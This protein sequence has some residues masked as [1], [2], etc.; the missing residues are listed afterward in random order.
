MKRNTLHAIALA[1]SMTPLAW[2]SAN[3]A[4]GVALTHVHG[5]T[6]A[7]DGATLMVPSHHGLAV[8]S[9]GQWSKA[10]GPEHDY[11][12]FAGTR[13]A[14]YSS[15]HPAPGSGLKN[16]F[17]L[18]KSTDGGKSWKQL[19]LQGESDFHTLAAS[20]GTNAVY[21]VN[22][23]PNSQMGTQGVYFTTNDGEKW[24]RVEAAGLAGR[25]HGLAV[26]PSDS[27]TVAAAADQGLFLSKD[28]G[29]SFKPVAS[30]KR[31]LAATFTVSGNE[32]WWSGH[33]GGPTLSVLDLRSGAKPRTV[34]LPDL[35]DDAV[36]FI[37]QNPVRTSEMAI[38]TFKKSIFVS[39][40]AGKSWA[41]I[42]DQGEPVADQAAANTKGRR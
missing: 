12:G 1:V 19:V 15:G 42:A 26:H 30:G 3:A 37:A 18:I 7:A 5:L 27:A 13:N 11:M 17:G 4:A 8:Y 38:A 39:K 23:H 25:I 33:D 14:L 22:P 2:W 40:D 32:I 20:Y 35:G 24:Q 41:R 36:S 6:Y 21:V 9:S 31:V 29:A 10:P 28:A 16:P 34:N